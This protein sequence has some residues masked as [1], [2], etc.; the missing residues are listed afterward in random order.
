MMI[1]VRTYERNEDSNQF[2]NHHVV[3]FIINKNKID[4]K[5]YEMFQ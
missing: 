4:L 2:S 3:V 5:V 1:E